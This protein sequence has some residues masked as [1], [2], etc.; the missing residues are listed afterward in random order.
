MRRSTLWDAFAYRSSLR[1]C[2][3]RKIYPT[4][5]PPPDA[6]SGSPLYGGG[7]PPTILR[8]SN[9][10]GHRPQAASRRRGQG[11]GLPLLAVKRPAA[12][13]A[14]RFA[15]IAVERLAAFSY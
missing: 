2:R 5:G 7:S 9:S 8:P 3:M 1:R 11:S 13:G 14:E 12:L 10:H 4:R 15:A 6:R